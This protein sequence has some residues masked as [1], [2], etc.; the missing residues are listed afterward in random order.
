MKYFKKLFFIVIVLL[1]LIGCSKNKP[2]NTPVSPSGP[3]S[4][5]VGQSLSFSAHTTDPED[6]DIA[7]QFDWGDGN[8]SSWS[9]HA[10]SGNSVTQNYIYGLTGIYEVRVK[11]KDIKE[12]E[13]DWSSGHSIEITGSAGNE[14][15]QKWAFSTGYYVESSPAIEDDGTIYVG[16]YDAHLYAINPDGTE[17]WAFYTIHDVHSSPA[18][19]SDGTIY[20][21]SFDGNLYAV[22]PDG[23]EKWS[24]PIGTAT[25]A[26]AI[27]LDGTI[28][29][30]SWDN[31]LYAINPDGTN[32][33]SSSI[34]SDISS[35]PAIGPDGTIYVGSLDNK[36]YAIYGSSGGLANSPWPMFHHDL[37]HSGREGGP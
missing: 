4:G 27:G 2:P 34:V 29:I 36:V 9:S 20:V 26:P 25:K 30:G 1:I 7:Y 12:A 8:L 15:T 14:G 11:A 37:K 32:K 5:V 23:T 24:F 33:W 31:N 3:S 19:G 35:S 18:I 28:Y 17:K 6:N 13:S 22:N 21:G 10:P 16:S